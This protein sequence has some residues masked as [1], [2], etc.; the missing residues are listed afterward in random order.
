[1]FVKTRAVAV[2]VAAVGMIGFGAPLASAATVSGPG[3]NGG[4]VNISHNQ[5]PIQGCSNQVGV[6]VAGGGVPVDG[7]AIAAALLG[8]TGNAAANT[9]QS[10]HLKNAQKN[11]SVAS[12]GMGG[13]NWGGGTSAKTV[14]AS[15]DNGGLVNVSHNQIPVQVCNNEVAVGVL[16]GAA[17]L[18]DVAGALGILG[19][20][21]SA[22]TNT[23]KSCHLANAQK[24]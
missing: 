4:L 22:T 20:T 15:S 11:V 21:G 3:D 13:N 6:G 24:G 12:Y 16:G 14:T 18:S 23:D 9:D 8:S 5:V 1:M 7:A 19:S 17:D 10:C 2:A